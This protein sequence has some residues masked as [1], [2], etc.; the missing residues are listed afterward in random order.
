RLMPIPIKY[1]LRNVRV[2]WVTSLL[3]IVGIVLVTVVFV[4]MFAM[5]LGMERSLVGSGDPLLMIALRTGTTAESQSVVTK[6][7]YDDLVGI[8]GLLRNTKGDLMVSPELVVGANVVKR[9]GGK[10]NV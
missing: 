10:A 9:D 5:G 1:N 3:T 8:P 7:Q 2:R 4:W 6:Q